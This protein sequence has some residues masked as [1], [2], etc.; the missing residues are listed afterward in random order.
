MPG[1]VMAT[2]YSSQFYDEQVAG[3]LRSAEEVL[4]LV[5]RLCKPRSVID[6]GC[7]RGA[8]LSVAEQF[9]AEAL[10]GLDGDWMTSDQL[11]SKTIK[12][13]PTNLAGNFNLPDC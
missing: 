8:W 9:G 5:W 1:L 13:V 4:P 7:G 2:P 12:F 10:T 11:L 6:V 3:S